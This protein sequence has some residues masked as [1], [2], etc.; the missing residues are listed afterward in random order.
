MDLFSHVRTIQL[1]ISQPDA[2]RLILPLCLFRLLSGIYTMATIIFN[3]LTDF[4]HD[5]LAW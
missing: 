2:Y 5:S 4:V 1:V 3:W